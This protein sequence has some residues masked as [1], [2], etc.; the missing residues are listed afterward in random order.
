MGED[1]AGPGSIYPHTGERRG[2]ANREQA[3]SDDC[4]KQI[5]LLSENI[6]NI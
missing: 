2:D 1:R 3:Q 5:Q 6:L 4:R